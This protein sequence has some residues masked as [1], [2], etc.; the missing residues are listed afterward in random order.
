MQ[1]NDYAGPNSKLGIDPRYGTGITVVQDAY[2]DL[3]HAKNVVCPLVTFLRASLQS[4]TKTADFDQAPTFGSF[5]QI[6]NWQYRAII[7]TDNFSPLHEVKIKHH[8]ATDAQLRNTIL[9]NS[10]PNLRQWSDVTFI[11]WSERAGKQIPLPKAVNSLKYI[12]T[13]QVTTKETKEVMGEALSHVTDLR[14]PP[15]PGIY[16]PLGKEE[17][18]AL[19]GTPHGKGVAYLLLDHPVG[20]G[21]RKNVESI[22]MFATSGQMYNLLFTLTD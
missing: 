11:V 12:F 13:N 6:Y 4:S 17:M 3:C 21:S 15:W 19:M 2:F 8:G 1:V 7:G 16:F 22:H 9:P 10:L 18:R 14:M 5:R 20:M